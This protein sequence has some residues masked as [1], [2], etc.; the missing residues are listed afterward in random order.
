MPKG[1]WGQN[2]GG[3]LGVLE[4][5]VL[6]V[7]RLNRQ[8]SIFNWSTTFF[9]VIRYPRTIPEIFT[10]RSA[11]LNGLIGYSFCTST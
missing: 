2:N 1:C 6:T 8:K 7:I 3:G 11:K 10:G 9:F 4:C 5:I